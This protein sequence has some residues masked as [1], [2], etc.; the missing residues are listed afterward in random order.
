[1]TFGEKLAKLR[2]RDNYTQEQL[3]DLLGVSRQ[4]VSRWESDLAYPETD[5][6]IKLAELFGCSVDY[7]LKE[8][9]DESGKPPSFNPKKL[10]FE[11]KSQRTVGGLPLWHVNI[12]I[13]RTAKGVIAI[14]LRAQGVLSFGLLSIGVISFGILSLGVIAFGALAIGLIGA[15]AI[16]AGIIALG[17]ICFGIIAVGAIA[18]GMF[19]LGATAIGQFSVGALAVG[20]YFAMGDSAYAQIAIGKTHASGTVFETDKITEANR[21]QILN[22]L[23]GSVPKAFT[24][25]IGLIKPYLQVGY[26]L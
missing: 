21:E 9:A 5:K 18:F 26:P 20:K 25:L 17:A 14:G 12:G 6:L 22:L 4:A 19:A 3:A 23:K 1:M 2:K 24:W 7:L 10:Y 16:S 11:K 8:D 13:G 15:G